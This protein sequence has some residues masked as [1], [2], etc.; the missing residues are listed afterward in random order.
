MKKDLS[1]DIVLSLI[2]RN[3]ELEK[4]NTE[5]RQL[6]VTLRAEVAELKSKLAAAQKNSRNSSKPP[7]SD[8][9]KPKVA[10]RKG[11]KRKIGAQIGHEAKFRTPIA[12]DQIDEHQTYE[13]ES[14]TCDCGGQLVAEPQSDRVRQQ[15]DLPER[16]LRV[17]ELRGKAYR[18]SKCGRHHY[19]QIPRQAL[20]TGFVGPNLAAVLAYLK[21]KAHAS[22]TALSCFTDEVLGCRVS[23]GEL[24]KTFQKIS[25]TLKEPY[26]EALAALPEESSLNIDETGHKENGCRMWTW[27]FRAPLFAVFYISFQRSSEVLKSVLG[28]NFKGLLGCDYFS[29]YHKYL[30]SC[31]AEAQFCLAHFIRDVRFLTTSSHEEVQSYALRILARL[32]LLFRLYHRTQQTPALLDKLRRCGQR[33]RREA[34]DA[35]EVKSAQNIANR[36]RLNGDSYLRFIDHPELEPTNN[37][38]EQTIRFV[39]LDRAVT[40]GTRSEAGRDWSA[41]AWTVNATCYMRKYS[42][43]KFLRQ[44]IDAFYSQKQYPSLLNL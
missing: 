28:L 43:F 5:L 32:R 20:A 38:A 8:I 12:A 6:L 21:I 41:R 37:L 35:P 44:A 24:A 7:S 14:A 25:V 13:P 23:R 34:L 36:F 22:Y 4:E 15:I 26:E 27:V 18:C 31:P 30:K 16:P 1:P 11:K 10:K 2:Q 19:G 29:A 40:Q 42:L 17:R 39:V 9:T 3:V 33:L